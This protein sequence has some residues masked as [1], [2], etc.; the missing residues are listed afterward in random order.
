MF[1]LKQS[2]AEWRCQML[3]AG[4]KTPV[5]LE[6]LEIHLHEEIGRLVESGLDEQNAFNTAVQK[7]GPMPAIRNEFENAGVAQR[8]RNWL[9]FEIFFLA[10]ALCLPILVG[11]QAFYLKD[12]RFSEMTSSQQISS[13]AAAATLSFLA[14]GMRFICG[15]FPVVHTKR[16]RDAILGS[17]VIWLLAWVALAA[18]GIM[19]RYDFSEAQKGVASLWGFVPFGILVGWASGHANAARKKLATTVS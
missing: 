10:G 7:M 6:E 5:P 12:G 18:A 4:I 14:L 16:I 15:K 11:A 19:P 8:G 1:D 17:V 2:I 3:A 9:I 13:L